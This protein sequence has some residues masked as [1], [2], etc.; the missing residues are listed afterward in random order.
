VSNQEVYRDLA[1]GDPQMLAR[2]GI[3]P[4]IAQLAEEARRKRLATAALTPPRTAPV[5]SPASVTSAT[6]TTATRPSLAEI[7]GPGINASRT[8]AGLAPLTSAE[9]EHEFADVD[10]E[11]MNATTKKSARR[12]AAN[13]MAARQGLPTD[14]AAIDDRWTALATKLNAAPREPTRRAAGGDARQPPGG[15]ASIDARWATLAANLNKQ[16]GLAK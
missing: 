13:A 9:L 12:A 4:R 5:R 15:Q 11:P 7:H 1:G 6:P 16:A 2:L 10:R 8:R 14:Q 3:P